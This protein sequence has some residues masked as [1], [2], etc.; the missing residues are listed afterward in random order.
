[1]TNNGDKIIYLGLRSFLKNA[2]LHG[3]TYDGAGNFGSMD[4]YMWFA[5]DANRSIND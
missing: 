3:I 5:D 1:M 4:F 2:T